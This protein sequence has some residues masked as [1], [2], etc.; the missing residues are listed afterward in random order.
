MKEGTRLYRTAVMTVGTGAIVDYKYAKEKLRTDGYVQ[1]CLG[2]SVT[3]REAEVVANK[4]MGCSSSS[5][6][7]SVYNRGGGVCRKLL[8]EDSSFV[9]AAEGT[10]P[11]VRV[12]P[13]NEMAYSEKFPEAVCFLMLNP[14]ASGGF[15]EL[16][17]NLKLTE[18]LRHHGI[19][20]KLETLGL[21]YVRLLHDEKD[22][23]KRGF[24]NSW[25]SA[26]RGDTAAVSPLIQ[27]C[28]SKRGLAQPQ[29]WERTWAPSVVDGLVF[30]SFLNRHHSWLDDD[31]VFGELPGEARPYQ[32]FWGDGSVISDEELRVVREA[33]EGCKTPLSLE[34]GDLIVVDN[35]RIS[36]G[37]STF[38]PGKERR[39]MGLLLGKMRNIEE[40]ETATKEP[41]FLSKV[42]TTN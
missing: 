32:C 35:I 23:G 6:T 20:E 19:F 5:S 7:L 31:E 1:L 39:L 41:P 21:Q 30:T 12:Q 27:E 9:D 4:L 24:Y 22:R 15:T 2:P 18:E 36:H 33:Y 8:Q 13:H 42:S 28:Y 25:E 16:Y 37:R 38:T 26:A 40:Y 17:D 14:A 3:A 11:N 10:S 29:K 34:K